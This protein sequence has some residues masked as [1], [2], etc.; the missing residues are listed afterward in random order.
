[1]KKMIFGLCAMLS[2]FVFTSCGSNSSD[3]QSS[4]SSSNSSP[5]ETLKSI[6]K[7]IENDNDISAKDAFEYKKKTLETEIAF[8]KSDAT[9][10]EYME[11]TD[12]MHK[13]YDALHKIDYDILGEDQKDELRKLDD[14]SDEARKEFKKKLKGKKE[15]EKR[16]EKREEK[17]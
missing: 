4:S 3:S 1:M 15:E 14:E 12:A 8:Y 2:S 5:T 16:K 13:C 17:Y 6:A 11:F 9:E 10:E 7:D